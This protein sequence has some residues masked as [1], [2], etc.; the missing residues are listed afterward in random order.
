MD[1][2]FSGPGLTLL[3]I[4]L[5]ITFTGIGSARGVAI[6][7]QTGSGLL[8]EQPDMFGKVLGLQALPMTQGIYGL[9]TAFFVMLL[10]GFFDGSFAELTMMDGV[11]YLVSCL[12]IAIVGWISA[13]YQARVAASGVLLLGKQKDKLGQA[14]TSAALVETYAIFALLITLMLVIAKG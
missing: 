9:L 3:G 12:P 5:A 2:I 10:A 13:I 11:Y 1:A 14:I 8:T 4:F 6:V 7:G